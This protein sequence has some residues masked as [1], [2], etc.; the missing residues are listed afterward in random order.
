MTTKPPT[1][2][3]PVEAP[4]DELAELRAMVAELQAKNKAQ[5]DA[6]AKTAAVN[7][8][9]E[10]ELIEP[11]DQKEPEPTYIAYRHYFVED[12]VQKTKDYRMKTED[13]AAICAERGW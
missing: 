11:K 2:E 6:A 10:P 4:V 1:T 9:H 13:F 8:M 3:P 5:E 7:A 12:G